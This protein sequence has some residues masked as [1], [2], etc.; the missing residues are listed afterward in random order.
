LFEGGAG[1]PAFCSRGSAASRG[2][3]DSLDKAGN[4]STLPTRE[5][6]Q[7]TGVYLLTWLL[8]DKRQNCEEPSRN[9]SAQAHP[10]V[11]PSANHH[12]D[13]SDAHV[14]TRLVLAARQEPSENDALRYI[15][16]YTVDPIII[17]LLLLFLTGRWRSHNAVA[18]AA[19]PLQIRGGLQARQRPVHIEL[20]LITRIYAPDLEGPHGSA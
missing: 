11:V 1:R 7:L 15:N 18:L 20:R 17:A 9:H 10:F 4:D 3:L 14:E 8:S 2:F 5:R 6:L 12:Q 16:K 19:G 13:D